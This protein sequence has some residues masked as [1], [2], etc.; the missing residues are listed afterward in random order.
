MISEID[1]DAI[2]AAAQAKDAA[3]LRGH[4]T[5]LGFLLTPESAAALEGLAEAV[6][7]RGYS[8]AEI[9]L[10]D[11]LGAMTAAVHEASGLALVEVLREFGLGKDYCLAVRT[12]DRV[13]VGVG[14]ATNAPLPVGAVWPALKPW[15]KELPK[16][17]ERAEKWAARAAKDRTAVPR[18]ELAASAPAGRSE[19]DLLREVLAA[20]GDDAPRRVLADALLG[21]G[22][23]RGELIQLQCDLASMP[24]TE[25]ARAY[26]AVGGATLVR[27]KG[28]WMGGYVARHADGYTL[29][30]GFVGSVTMKP[31]TFRRHGQRLLETHPIETVRPSPLTGDALSVLASA[32]ALRLVRRL[33][34]ECPIDHRRR[35]PALSDLAAGDL[36]SLR[37]LE[38]RNVVADARTWESFLAKL[39]APRLASIVFSTGTVRPHALRGLAQN[40][41]VRGLERLRLTFHFDRP[42]AGDEPVLMDAFRD[43]GRA[44]PFASLKGVT[45]DGWRGVSDRHVAAWFDGPNAARLEDLRMSFIDLGDDAARA[46]AASPHSASLRRLDVASTEVRH[47]GIAALLRS[48]HL[49]ALESLAW[50]EIEPEP[51]REL[52]ELALAL[53]RSHPLR[54]LSV[55]PDDL[56]AP[57]RRRF[58]ARFAARAG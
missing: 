6:R 32:P 22:D 18:V 58:A 52:A 54:H 13:V 20:P 36:G 56:P 4:G 46:I 31:A 5:S 48:P 35:A 47:E 50:S 26:F 55:D 21:R 51:T 29:Q 57:L 28:A 24:R 30:R 10:R 17:R 39:R 1:L 41:V 12:P 27:Y 15:Y 44:A 9:S 25:P 37:E 34:L 45:L 16:N 3:A 53:P 33:V 40:E 11:V 14:H 49:R 38:L 8:K 43:L 7:K 19:E 23:L 42:I 2:V